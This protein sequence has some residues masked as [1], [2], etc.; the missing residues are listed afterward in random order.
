LQHSQSLLIVKANR[1]VNIEMKRP[2]IVIFLFLGSL[3]ILFL[4]C[5]DMNE[6]QKLKI[7]IMIISTGSVGAGHFNICSSIAEWVN[8]RV[9]GYPITAVPGSGGIGNPMRVG[10]GRADIGVSYGPFLRMAREGKKAPFVKSYPNLRSICS[11]TSNSQHFLVSKDIEANFLEDVINEK[12][13]LK[14]ATGFPGTSDRFILQLVLGELG[15]TEEIV[16]NWGGS[17]YQI[18]TSGRVA[19]WKDRHINALHSS[20]EFPAAAIT[21]AMVSRK[22]HLLGLNDTIRNNLVEKLGFIKTEIPPK[23]YPGQNNPVPTVKL[24]M[25]LFTTTDA[26]ED[27]IYLFARTIAES[28]DRF[29]KAYGSFKDWQPE[30]MIQNL[31]IPIH[32]GALTYYKERGWIKTVGKEEF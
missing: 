15:I 9:S 17:I 4:S 5:V 1:K 10:M 25:V 23:S 11:L 2:K 18:G 24:T 32:R 22:G 8:A 26:N 3:I 29:S 21:E 6:D 28:Q 31:G 12:V 19:L 13:K 27:A 14:I 7:P 16:K 20:I 30:D